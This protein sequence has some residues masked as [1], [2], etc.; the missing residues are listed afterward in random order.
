M[1]R[2]T[3][4]ILAL[5]LCSFSMGAAA[6]DGDLPPTG[7]SRFD[8]L[9]GD[10]PVPYPLPR[11][12]ALIRS[13]L[14]ASRDG[15]SPIKITLIPLGRS[16]RRSVAEPDFFHFPSVVAVVDGDSKEGHTQLK[17]QLFL[18]YN[19]RA[20]AVEIISYN[21]QAGRFEFQVV[22][23]YRSG[24]Q[25]KI[26]YASRALCLACHQNNAPIFSRPLWD[27]TTA[28]PAI[29][30][31]LKA[32]GR[33]FYGIPLSGTDIASAIDAAAERANM[34]QVWLQIWRE[35]CS[36]ACRA[37]WLDAALVYALSGNLPDADQLKFADLEKHWEK[38]WPQGLGIPGSSIP[39][40]DPFANIVE[41][42]KKSHV[43]SSQTMAELA[44][45]AYIPAQLEPLATRPPSEHWTTPDKTR[46]VTGLAG[47]LNRADIQAFDRALITNTR[48]QSQTLTL[49]CRFTRKPSRV[50]FNCA[51]PDV[52]FSGVFKN[53]GSNFSGQIDRLQVGHAKTAL[54]LPLSGRMA[55]TGQIE[56]IPKRGASFV[57]LSDGRRWSRLQFSTSRAD[58]GSA[59]LTLID[60]YAAVR[61]VLPRLPLM[62]ASIFDGGRV[63]P[64]VHAA[65]GLAKREVSARET[66]TNKLPPAKLEIVTPHKLSGS[67][68]QFLQYCGQCHDS[69]THLPPN[70]LHGDAATVN[71]RLD[72]CA[73]RIFY[74]LS[75]WHV[76]EE[77]RGKTAMPP[78]SALAAYGFNATS[79]ASSAPLAELLDAVRQRIVM[80]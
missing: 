77:K 27:E 33:N 70:F 59:T 66:F 17:D 31:R 75:M 65:L 39:N 36:N 10:A 46:L 61:S 72:H 43:V 3:G 32:T 74:R 69:T 53:A 22:R 20:E 35:A 21:E 55:K 58:Q 6:D 29:A 73:E 48:A 25:P 19:E 15:L 18:G 63:L 34:F 40:R 7:R 9:M 24:A 37:E 49:P 64:E 78:N 51:S 42:K 26:F 60:D 11:L 30:S 76:A 57:R 47:L 13:Q 28:N 68:A 44:Q 1:N 38:I 23:D 8:F 2:I 80:Q 62:K 54:D 50:V 14:E 4:G 52:Q 45:L 71:T 5:L 56:L 12:I 41:P 79:W 67:A 16:L